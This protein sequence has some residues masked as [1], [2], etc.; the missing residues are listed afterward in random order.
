MEITIN[1]EVSFDI[2]DK[3]KVVDNLSFF[4]KDHLKEVSFGTSINKIIIVKYTILVK[5]AVLIK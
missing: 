3:L 1:K 4:V 5:L 2:Y